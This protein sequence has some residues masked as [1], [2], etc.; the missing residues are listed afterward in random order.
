M[1]NKKSSPFVDFLQIF[2]RKKS[3]L[4]PVYTA[5]SKKSSPFV[6]F[7]HTVYG[8]GN[9]VIGAIFSA[10]GYLLLEIRHLFSRLGF[11]IG[12]P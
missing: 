10:G 3:N 9:S 11:L 7:L 5:L 6:D 12:T 1:L 4:L 2:L 8:G